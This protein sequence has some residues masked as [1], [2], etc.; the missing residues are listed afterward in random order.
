MKAMLWKLGFGYESIDVCRYD[1]ALFRDDHKD[2]DHCPVCGFTRWKV[3]KDC[4][5]KVPHKVLCYFPI[6]PRLQ[7]LFMSKQRAQYTRWHKEKRVPVENEMRHPADGEAWKDFNETFKSFADDP[8]NLR[9]SI[10]TDGFNPF[11]QMSNTYSIWPVIVVP[12]NFPPWMCMDQS[13]YMLALLIPG[14]KSLGK[15]LHVYMQPLIKDMIQ[16]WKGVQTYDV[17]QGK[18]FSQH[19]AILWGIHDYPALGT[20]SGRTTRGYFACVHCD[21]MLCSECLRGKIGFLNHR[22][23]L[24][25]DHPWRRN[26]SFN[27]KHEKREKPRKFSADEVMARLEE[28]RYVPGKNPHVPKSRKRRRTEGEPVW[29]LKVS[30]YDLPYWSKLKLQYNLDVMHIE[31]NICEA[32]LYTLLNIPNKTKDTISARLDLEDRGIHKEIH[33]LYDSGSSSSKPRACY[34]LKPEDKK[35]FLQFVSNVKFPDG[36]ASNISR[37]VNMEGGGSTHGLKTHDC[38]IMLQHILPVGLRGLVR[39]DLYEVIAELGRFLD[40]FAPK[41]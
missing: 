11:V 18:E 22:H 20:L 32:I 37:C 16:L 31:K 39:K 7:R 25:K 29:H 38:H 9:L 10:G 28:V 12:Y 33:L 14:K 41:L 13:N 34:V 26:R 21:E 35:K 1:C 40:N 30:L 36:Y 24:P 27:G 19:A 3:N 4:R 8:R 17:V 2:D 5:K 15:D 23:F 6:I